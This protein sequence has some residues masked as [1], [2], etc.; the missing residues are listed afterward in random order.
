MSGS[1][2][3]FPFVFI[4]LG[5]CRSFPFPCFCLFLTG[6]SLPTQHMVCT[7]RPPSEPS[8]TANLCLT[9]HFP[10][11]ISPGLS[12]PRCLTA[13]PILYRCHVSF[14]LDFHLHPSLPLHVPTQLSRPHPSFPS[15]NT[16]PSSRHSIHDVQ[17]NVKLT[18]RRP[19]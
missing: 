8:Y 6:G 1:V 19:I 13:K 2:F 4:S 14:S 10:V 9:S 12:Y 7:C 18:A 3:T 16:L 17:A 11:S 5:S 15:P